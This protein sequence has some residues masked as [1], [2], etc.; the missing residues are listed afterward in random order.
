MKGLISVVLVL[1]IALPSVAEAAGYRPRS[2][3][4]GLRGQAEQVGDSKLRS[5]DDRNQNVGWCH[6]HIKFDFT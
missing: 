1:A 6:L 2:V 5:F 4:V 3:S